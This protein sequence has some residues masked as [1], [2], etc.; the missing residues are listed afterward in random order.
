M[1]CSPIIL[2]QSTSLAKT[3]ARHLLPD[4]PPHGV[5]TS[6]PA[7]G[8]LQADIGCSHNNVSRY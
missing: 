1:H 5:R 3:T 4:R 6:R 8:N 7:V 2:L